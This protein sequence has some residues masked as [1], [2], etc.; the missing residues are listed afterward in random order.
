MPS[1]FSAAASVSSH[2]L[3]SSDQLIW[4]RLFGGPRA[5][6]LSEAQSAQS[7]TL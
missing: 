4:L 1:F 7:A 2:Q 3:F 5:Y 6:N